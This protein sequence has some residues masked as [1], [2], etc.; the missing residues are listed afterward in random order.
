MKGWCDFGSRYARIDSLRG[1]DKD[2]YSA[3]KQPS[4]WDFSDPSKRPARRKVRLAFFFTVYAD[5]PFVRRLFAHLYSPSHYYLFHIDAAG[6]S[7][8]FEEE[9][10]TLGR[11]RTNVHFA[12]DIKIVYGASTAT[13]LV[14]LY[15]YYT[16][17]KHFY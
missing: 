9:L 1:V 13:I 5:A 6:A 7:R 10:R 16:W 8:E 3:F 2:A 12:K 15:Q 11:N 4:V 14:P 17:L